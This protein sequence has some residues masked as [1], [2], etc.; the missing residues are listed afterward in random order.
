MVVRLFDL[1]GSLLVTKAI[2]GAGQSNTIDM[3]PFA[4]ATYLLEVTFPDGSRRHS[5]RIVRAGI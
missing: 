3:S 4:Q 2:S 1:N 5:Y